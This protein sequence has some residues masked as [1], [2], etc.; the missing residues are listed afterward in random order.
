MRN[1]LKWLYFQR[2]RFDQIDR[3]DTSLTE[4]ME[5]IHEWFGD[6]TNRS[7]PEIPREII[8][9]I[10]EVINDSTPG[11]AVDSIRNEVKRA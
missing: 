11:I 2:S 4:K 9:L 1:K 8:N 7:N 6:I 5:M 3:I 10:R